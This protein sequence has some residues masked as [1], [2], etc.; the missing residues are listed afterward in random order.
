ME[1]L[2]QLAEK[3]RLEK[4]AEAQ[5]LRAI[6]EERI[7]NVVRCPGRAANAVA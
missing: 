4:I 1:A 6:A 5:K 2:Q 3:L 7:A